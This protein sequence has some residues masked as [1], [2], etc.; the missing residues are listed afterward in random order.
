MFFKKPD[1]KYRSKDM[2]PALHKS[3]CTGETVAGFIDN[4][5]GRFKDI[6]LIKDDKDLK[7]FLKTY[8]IQKEDLKSDY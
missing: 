1:P 3:I 2:T 4:S 7:R 6:M 5:T 8:N